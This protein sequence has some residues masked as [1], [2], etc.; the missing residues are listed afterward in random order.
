MCIICTTD[1][2]TLTNLQ[3]LFCYN[4]KNLYYICIKDKDKLYNYNFSN[5]RF[6]NYNWVTHQD[7]FK[8]IIANRK[9]NEFMY[10]FHIRKQKQRVLALH[11]WRFG[12]QDIKDII[13]EKM[14]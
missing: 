2:S 5:T 11:L 9:I 3:V 12:L 1:H 7:R 6:A 14:F 10:K 8:Y 13:L 4:C